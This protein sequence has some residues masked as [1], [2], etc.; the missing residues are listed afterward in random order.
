MLLLGFSGEHCEQDMNVCS[1]ANFCQNN[2]SCVND[3]FGEYVCNCTEGYG[4]LNCSLPNCTQV[5][6][7]NGGICDILNDKWVCNCTEGYEGE[8]F[9]IFR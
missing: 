1:D 8:F 6:C 7:A 2:G 9:V 5:E 4:G 3:G